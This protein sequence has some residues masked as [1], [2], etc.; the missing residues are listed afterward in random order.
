MPSLMTIPRELRDQICEY[1][2]LSP[3]RQPPSLDQ[4]AEELL[5]GY[6]TYKNPKVFSGP[7]ASYQPRASV[8]NAGK[9]LLINQHLRAE[10]TEMLE[11]MRSNVVY[12][13]DIVMTE[14]GIM[15]A[16]WISIPF[17]T[18]EIE[19]LNVTFRF[20]VTNDSE[21]L[22]S[23][24]EDMSEAPANPRPED[25]SGLPNEQCKQILSLHFNSMK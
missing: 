3:A 11:R 5:D 9:L 1:V 21:Q 14:D 2:I 8:S 15:A 18:S 12:D 25:F 4:T 10:T 24:L 16:T 7:G 22:K 13:L 23:R 6:V 20:C 17:L 19:Q